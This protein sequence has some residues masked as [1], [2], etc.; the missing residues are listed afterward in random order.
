M[1]WVK[2]MCEY[3]KNEVHAPSFDN[4]FRILDDNFNTV[5]IHNFI[6]FTYIY[7]LYRYFTAISALNSI[8]SVMR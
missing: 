5:S 3:M 7:Y 1:R 4:N 8:Y 6:F 2:C